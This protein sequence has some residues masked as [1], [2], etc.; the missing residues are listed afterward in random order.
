MDEL[1]L[2]LKSTFMRS[3]IT[4]LIGT[5]IRKQLG[6]DIDISINDVNVV[7]VDGKIKLHLDVDAETTNEEFSKIIKSVM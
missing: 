4:K 2:S 5:V 6:Y 1:K 3:I 7:A